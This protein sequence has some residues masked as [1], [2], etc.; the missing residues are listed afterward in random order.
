MPLT[1]DEK[2]YI[3]DRVVDLLCAPDKKEK[4]GALRE[5]VMAVPQGEDRSLDEAVYAV[6]QAIEELYG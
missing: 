4:L 6:A 3:V 1:E 5:R 2:Q